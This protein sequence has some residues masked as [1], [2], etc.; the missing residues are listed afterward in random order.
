[1]NSNNVTEWSSEEL[2]KSLESELVPKILSELQNSN[3]DEVIHLI[4]NFYKN[5]TGKVVSEEIQ[6]NLS[7]WKA[8]AFEQKGDYLEALTI[9]REINSNTNSGDALYIYQKIDI[10]RNLINYHKLEEAIFEIE[11]VILCQKDKISTFAGML[12]LL[13]IYVELLENI[14]QT[15]PNQHETLI[16]KIAQEIGINMYEALNSERSD[17]LHSIIKEIFSKY[18]EANRRYQALVLELD[19]AEDGDEQDKILDNYINDEEVKYY[20]EKARNIFDDELSIEN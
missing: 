10:V 20:R 6:R 4:D 7:G 3:P 14:S 2:I 16:K 8:F 11:S 9:F 19:S 12:R 15:I 1:M 17:R 5:H 13:M 18:R